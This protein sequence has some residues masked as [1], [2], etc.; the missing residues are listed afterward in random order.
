MA[1]VISR[2]TWDKT[3]ERFKIA[4]YC[5]Y[6]KQRGDEAIFL[7]N[8]ISAVRLSD[9]STYLIHPR[10]L[11]PFDQ[12]KAI[13]EVNESVSSAYTDKLFFKDSGTIALINND[14]LPVFDED[15]FRVTDA[16]KAQRIESL[17]SV[18]K[19]TFYNKLREVFQTHAS[20]LPLPHPSKDRLPKSVT[21]PNTPV[22]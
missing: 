13:V 7:S 22:A 4:P 6:T 21:T 12:V 17:I 9:E 14:L 1:S 18:A 10:Y 3:V 19:E 2:E 8:Y 15:K 20:S 16:E 11:M 5:V